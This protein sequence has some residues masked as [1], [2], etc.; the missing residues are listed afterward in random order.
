MWMTHRPTACMEKAWAFRGK[1][2][3]R[4]CEEADSNFFCI[5]R[6]YHTRARVGRVWGACATRTL[7]PSLSHAKKCP[8][9]LLSSD[10]LQISLQNLVK[11]LTRF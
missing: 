6:V 7:S 10:F 4:V 5:R 11:K 3:V 2:G 8:V 9:H 1:I